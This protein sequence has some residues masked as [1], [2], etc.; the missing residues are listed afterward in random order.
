MTAPEKK[1]DIVVAGAGISGI[2]AAIELAEMDCRVLLLDRA[3]TIGGLLMQLDH[4]FP[5]NGC[6]MC[7]MLPMIG[8]D[9]CTSTCLRRGLDH[10]RIDIMTSTEIASVSGSP[11][12]LTV[13]LKVG[14]EAESKSM[15]IID[16]GAVI[17]APGVELFDPAA[18]DVYGYGVLPNVVTALSFEQMLSSSGPDGGKLLR[19]SDRQPVRRIA[20]VQCVGSRNIMLDAP[21]CSTSCC[22][23]AVKEA[24]LAREKLGPDAETTIYYMDMRTFGRDYQ[25]YRDRAEAS[26][27]RFVRC[28]IHSIDPGD[29]PGD[30][31]ITYVTP[32]GEKRGRDSSIWRSSPP[33]GDPCGKIPNLHRMKGCTPSKPGRILKRSPNRLSRRR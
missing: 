32:E 24:M 10:E 9:E 33:A 16:V 31:K 15:E 3:N 6:G 7:R 11:G 17:F 29:A 23:F 30:L 28:R 4:Q 27:V 1:Y 8:T 14:A 25:R 2:H 20:W 5:G 12:D 13:S 18:V 22:M 19:P 26:G 21:H